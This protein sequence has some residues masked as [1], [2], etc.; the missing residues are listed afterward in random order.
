MYLKGPGEVYM[1][2]RDNCVFEAPQ[3]SFPARKRPGD[4]VRDTLVDGVRAGS[5]V[6]HTTGHPPA[7]CA[8]SC[9]QRQQNRLLTCTALVLVSSQEMVLDKT[10]DGVRPRFLMYDIMQFEVN[11]MYVT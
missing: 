4:C 5:T 9:F 3:L 6:M 10:P 2:G 1:V 11:H 7:D 8:L